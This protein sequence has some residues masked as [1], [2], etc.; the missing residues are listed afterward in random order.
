MH[1]EKQSRVGKMLERGEMERGAVELVD[2]GSPVPQGH[3]LRKAG[4]AVDFNK[5]YEIEGPL[6]RGDGGRP[7]PFAKCFLA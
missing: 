4:G 5:I 3:L 1:M 6:Y 7:K 2:T